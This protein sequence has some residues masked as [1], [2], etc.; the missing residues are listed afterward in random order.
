MK[1]S[2]TYIGTA[3]VLL[4]IGGLR[5]VTDPVL[6]PPGSQFTIGVSG[7]STYTSTDAPAV[8]AEALDTA[9]IVLLSHD[10]H[11]DNLDHEGRCFLGK[12]KKILTTPAAARRLGPGLGRRVV[13]LRPW[14]EYQAETPEGDPIIITATPARHGPPLSLPFVGHVVG[15]LLKWPGQKDGPLYI[16]GDTVLY[17]GIDQIASREKIGT[18]LLHVGQGGFAATGPIR[19]SMDG[20]DAAKATRKLNASRTIPIHFDG[21]DHFRSDRADIERAF[22]AEGL[23][24]KLTWLPRGNRVELEI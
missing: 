18:A 3:T 5:I 7:R 20:L 14:D 16:S 8:N 12:A 23:S 13:G 11:G 4:E 21:W 19:F 24:D 6:D 22:E 2:M 15:F 10:Q 17:R 9:D 1:I